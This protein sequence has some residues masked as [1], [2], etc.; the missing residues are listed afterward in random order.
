VRDDDL[1]LDLDDEP[2]IPAKPAKPT[3][4][5]PAVKAV[6]SPAAKPAVAVGTKAPSLLARAKSYVKRPQFNGRTFLTLLLALLAL[7][8]LAENF[9]PVRFYLLGLA[10]EL[11]KALCFLIDVALG[12]ALMWWWLRRPTSP[13]EA[14]K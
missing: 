5:A 11:P 13:V 6:P 12:A 14:G 7:V 2:V 10:L 1:D 8:I 3:K 4:P 9:A